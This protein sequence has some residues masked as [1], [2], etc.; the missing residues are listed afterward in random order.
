[1]L[2]VLQPVLWAAVVYAAL[3]LCAQAAIQPYAEF[4][5]PF[6]RWELGWIAP[7]YQVQQFD[8]DRPRGELAFN[9]LATNRGYLV[10]LSRVIPPRSL[11]FR[12]HILVMRGLEHV[13]M[14]LLVPLAWPGLTWKRRLAAVACAIP[15]LCL[16]EFADLPWVMVGGFD[17]LRSQYVPAPDS[18]P[19]I[20]SQ[21]EETGGHFALALFAG[22]LACEM[23]SVFVAK[24]RSPERA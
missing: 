4:V 23:S 21:I 12:V 3:T 2:R 9:V 16:V 7:D 17:S 14:L 20:W 19:M 24:K 6:Y 13:V 15:L 5:R 1:V 10:N 8:I 11:T 18:F 22:V